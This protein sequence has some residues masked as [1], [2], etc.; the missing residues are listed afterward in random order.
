[1]HAPPR[2]VKL[3]HNMYSVP[4]CESSNEV[5]EKHK[6]FSVH[7]CGISTTLTYA[8]QLAFRIYAHTYILQVRD[9]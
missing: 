5:S 2:E 1:M 4:L 3:G 8:L 7:A 6:L 9:S